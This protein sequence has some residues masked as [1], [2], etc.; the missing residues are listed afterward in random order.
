MKGDLQTWTMECDVKRNHID[1]L[2]SIMANHGFSNLPKTARTLLK[3]PTD[4]P[5]QRLAG[6]S[7][8]LRCAAESYNLLSSISLSIN[9]DG[10]PKVKST[11][12]I[13]MA[14]VVQD[15]QSAI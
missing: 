13:T 3:T 12:N 9:I 4:V 5:V 14:S 8:K 2:L 10:L 6:I 11:K 7:D 15:R 1:R